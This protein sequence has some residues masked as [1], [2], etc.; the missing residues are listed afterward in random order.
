[1]TVLHDP[2]NEAPIPELFV[3]LSLDADGNE[4][5]TAS[6]LPNLGST[7]LV[8]SKRRIAEQMKAIAAEIARMSGKPV[9]LVRFTAGDEIWR[10]P[11]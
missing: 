7:P 10:S 2:P 5:I 3:F 4:G 1:M 6:I 9:R 11:P 8:T